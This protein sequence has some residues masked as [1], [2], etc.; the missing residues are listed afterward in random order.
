MKET[1][2]ELGQI[3]CNEFEQDG[4]FQVLE[5]K[6]YYAIYYRYANNYGVTIYK[7]KKEEIFEVELFQKTYLGN[8]IISNTIIGI[9]KNKIITSS[10]KEVNEILK[11]V[12][13]IEK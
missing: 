11:K 9:S 13:R 3:F 7:S 2:L 8:K 4:V 6:G 10:I 1:N 12:K 5:L